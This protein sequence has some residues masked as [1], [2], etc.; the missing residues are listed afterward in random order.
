M[1]LTIAL[2]FFAVGIAL[3]LFAIVWFVLVDHWSMASCL[4]TG[5]FCGACLSEDVSSPVTG[6]IG[7][8]CL[9]LAIVLSLKSKGEP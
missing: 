8:G 3:I 2:V 5:Q 9:V 6:S 1:K 4:C 7:I